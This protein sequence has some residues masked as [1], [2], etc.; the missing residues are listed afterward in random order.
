MELRQ[1]KQ[2]V[3]VA[4]TLA[5]FLVVALRNARV[6]AEARRRGA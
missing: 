4:E 3:A 1:L 2:F 5:Q 6:F